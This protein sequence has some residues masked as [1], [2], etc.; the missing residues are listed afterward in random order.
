MLEL[1]KPDVII[2]TMA[3]LQVSRIVAEFGIKKKIPVVIDIRD[4]WPE[5]YYDVISPKLYFILNVYVKR[6]RKI[7]ESTFQK[8]YG[9]VGTSQEFLNYGLNYVKRDQSEC[10]IVIPIGYPKYDY[11]NYKNRFSEFW[12]RYDV[13]EKNFIVVFLGN[14]GDQFEFTPVIEASQRLE[15]YSDIKFILCGVGKHLNE[16]KEQVGDNVIFPGWAEKEEIITLLANSNIGLIP[17]INSIGFRSTTSNKFGE[18]LSAA[19]PICVSV[20]GNMENYLEK[21][22]CGEYYKDGSDLA[23]KIEK[24][25][26][27]KERYKEYSRNSKKLYEKLFDN[28]KIND[29]MYNFLK[30]IIVMHKNEE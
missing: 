29:E 13:D 16:V 18:Y 26:V 8:S 27:D 10:D 14:F 22:Q 9:I 6:C 25:Y 3:P 1:T 28:E 20:H 11:E 24:L 7:L 23:C 5:V 4:L 15:K 12:G 30:K 19:L 2:A 17:Y 21:N